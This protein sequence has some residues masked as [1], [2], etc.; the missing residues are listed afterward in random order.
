MGSTTRQCLACSLSDLYH[1]SPADWKQTPSASLRLFLST[2]HSFRAILFMVGICGSAP[3]K[4]QSV[5]PQ[6]MS[7]Y[8]IDH[9]HRRSLT[10]WVRTLQDTQVGG[11]FTTIV[12]QADK[13]GQLSWVSLVSPSSRNSSSLL[14]VFNP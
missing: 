4:F 8:T 11:G 6:A 14:Y 2:A 3:R 12:F 9:I 1:W 10:I 5:P 13:A 7:K